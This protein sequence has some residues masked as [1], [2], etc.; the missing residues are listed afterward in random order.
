MKKEYSKPTFQ[1]V[2]L[3]LEERIAWCRGWYRTGPEPGPFREDC[4]SYEDLST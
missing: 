2:K 4:Y 1:F 3:T